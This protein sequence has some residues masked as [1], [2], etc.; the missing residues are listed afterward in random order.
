MIVESESLFILS[1]RKIN[2]RGTLPLAASTTSSLLLSI[3]DHREDQGRSGEGLEGA[4]AHAKFVPRETTRNFRGP[5]LG[6]DV[7]CARPAPGAPL[8]ANM[9]GY[10]KTP[11]FNAVEVE[12][13]MVVWLVS[14]LLVAQGA[15]RI[16]CNLR[17][18]ITQQVVEPIQAR[19]E[20][21][22]TIGLHE[23]ESLD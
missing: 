4:V 21:Y 2:V 12:A 18:S 15:S 23:Y 3:R 22:A 5:Q 17:D 9:I 1:A 10:G 8:L 16:C 20:L 13:A 14:S 6:R 7:P 11:F 19:A